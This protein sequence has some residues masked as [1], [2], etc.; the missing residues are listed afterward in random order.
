VADHTTSKGRAVIGQPLPRREDP[1]HLQGRGC[2]TDDLLPPGTLA[3]MI[4]RSPHAHA[5]IVTLDTAAARDLPGV[6]AIYTAA[7]LA[8]HVAPLPCNWL[9]PG[10]ARA[11]APRTCH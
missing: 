3:V 1:R 2:F 10:I 5:R 9:L 11:R 4:L 6:I 8:G 7:D